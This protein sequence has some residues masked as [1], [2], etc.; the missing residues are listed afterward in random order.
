MLEAKT[1]LS[2]LIAELEEHPE[3]EVVISRYGRPVA[4]LVAYE[5]GAPAAAR[6]GSARG[7]FA[8]PEDIDAPYGDLS[9]V[10]AAN[11][12]ASDTLGERGLPGRTESEEDNE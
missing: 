7:A 11:G 9:A 8:V 6:I 10:F 4:R 5:T 2:R 1:H 3:S 12:T